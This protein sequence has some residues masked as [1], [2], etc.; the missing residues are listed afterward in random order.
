MFEL[1]KNEKRSSNN[2][3]DFEIWRKYYFEESLFEKLNDKAYKLWEDDMK[4]N[5]KA[6]HYWTLAASILK[7]EQLEPE[8]TIDDDEIKKRAYRLWQQKVRENGEDDFYLAQAIATEDLGNR[9][10]FYRLEKKI[11]EP[12]NQWLHR[13]DIFA[14]LER[15]SQISI[16]IAAIVFLA[17]TEAN[18]KG[19]VQE[20]WETI[21]ETDGQHGN[22]GRV[23]AIEYLNSR[24]LR[25]PWIGLT[26]VPHW[27]A[28]HKH[29][30]PIPFRRVSKKTCRKRP[31][32]GWKRKRQSLGGLSAHL[33]LD[34]SN[35]ENYLGKGLFLGYKYLCGANLNHANLQG[36]NLKQTDLSGANLR[37]ADLRGALLDKINFDQADLYAADLRWSSLSEV[38][39]PKGTNPR[40]EE[41]YMEQVDLGNVLLAGSDLEN[42]NLKA[43]KLMETNLEGANLTGADLEEANLTG[44]NLRG[45]YHYI[46][47]SDGE[48]VK[49]K[50]RNEDGLGWEEAL[51]EDYFPVTEIYPKAKLCNT[52]LPA[53]T[54]KGDHIVEG[55]D[56]RQGTKLI[57]VKGVKVSYRDCKEEKPDP[58][59]VKVCNENFPK[60]IKEK[61]EEKLVVENSTGK[62]IPFKKCPGWESTDENFWL[63]K[64]KSER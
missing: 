56:F 10:F 58:S 16:L 52:T 36:A 59:R 9:G 44:A 22:A 6:H 25:F 46:K 4:A 32:L 1:K 38:K 50:R 40:S 34:W 27:Q 57:P 17:N 49:V 31:G 37:H 23:K 63:K 42:V 19:R 53:D 8:N 62:P 55:R 21:G 15:V 41:G 18:Y 14:V 26:L 7:D 20:S 11:I 45:A 48:K 28:T 47:D 30:I 54:A 43:A 24:P 2:D 51:V 64:L 29:I 13:L 3:H 60:I 61:E 39:F 33:K 12:L 35:R 5:G